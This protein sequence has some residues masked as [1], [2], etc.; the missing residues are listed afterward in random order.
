MLEFV[1]LARAVFG[2]PAFHALASS[3]LIFGTY[4]RWYVLRMEGLINA[5]AIPSLL[6]WHRGELVA[7]DTDVKDVVQMNC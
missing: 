1:I 4:S 7:I 3:S 6:C 2:V 5:S